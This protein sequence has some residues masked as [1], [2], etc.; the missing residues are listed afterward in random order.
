MLVQEE[1][2]VE[3]ENKDGEFSLLRRGESDLYE[4]F[5]DNIKTLF[6]S[7]QRQYGHCTGK[8]RID[9]KDGGRAIGW[10]FSKI[11]YY[12]DTKEPYT[13]ETWVTLHDKQPDRT[14]THHYHILD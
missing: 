2:L 3:T 14:I 10:V 5:T 9:T 8:V 7:F 1:Y 12:E 13:A 6:L 4:P 11:S